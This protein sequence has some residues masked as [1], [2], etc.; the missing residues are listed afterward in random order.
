M[1]T[2]FFLTIFCAITWLLYSLYTPSEDQFFEAYTVDFILYIV[3]L[4]SFFIYEWVITYALYQEYMYLMFEK[5]MHP[6]VAIIEHGYKH[7]AYNR[8]KI[9]VY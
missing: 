3:L 4:I 7:P 2:Q 8:N 6:N 5:T 9:G 1:L